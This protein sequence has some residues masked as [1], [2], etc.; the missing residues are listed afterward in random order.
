[1]QKFQSYNKKV[2]KWILFEKDSAG[3]SIIKKQSK[4]KFKGVPVKNGK[5]KTS[6]RKS[7]GKS[8]VKI[9]FLR[10]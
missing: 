6:S 5:S 7:N 1:M 3:R 4:M 9:P 2:G 10:R 8:K